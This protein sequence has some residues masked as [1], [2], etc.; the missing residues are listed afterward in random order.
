MGR[1]G[2]WGVNVHFWKAGWVPVDLVDSVL[3]AR[4][5]R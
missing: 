3:V 2:G 4:G 5:Q 1:R